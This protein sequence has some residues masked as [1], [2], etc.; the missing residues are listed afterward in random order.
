MKMTMQSAGARS[1][2]PSARNG[3]L[4]RGIWAAWRIVCAVGW[5]GALSAQTAPVPTI[6]PS[7]R[8]AVLDAYQRYYIAVG[9]VSPGFTG[10]VATGD[11]G[12]VSDDY[13]R[14]TLSRINF[15]RA[16]AGLNGDVSFDPVLSAKCQQAALMMAV[17]GQLSHSPDSSW[18]D[19][20]ADGA[21]AANHSDLTLGV[22]GPA[23]VA[24]YFQD[25]GANNAIVGHRH[26]LLLAG[27]TVMG[28]GSIATSYNF[29]LPYGGVANAIWVVPVT[30]GVVPARP[31][32]TPA[33]VAWPTAGYFPAPLVPAR[34]SVWE[35]DTDFSGAVVQVWRD[36]TDLGT[37]PTVVA[38]REWFWEDA[39]VFS[40]VLPVG[41]PSLSRDENYHVQITGARRAS[42]G[43]AV[44]YDYTVTTI[45]PRPTPTPTPAV[46]PQ[47]SL[48][49]TADTATPLTKTKL[50]FT[51]T[52][53]TSA[54]LAVAYKVAGTAVGGVDYEPLG[55]TLTIPA[56]AASA[57]RKLKVLTGAQPDAT[58]EVRISGSL[59]Y[60]KDKQSKQVV[61]HLQP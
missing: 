39:L 29:A 9:S 49:A 12:T 38:D 21:E 40:P 4:L 47:I 42:T 2:Q 19:Y 16:L 57:R 58:V 28:S 1:R 26:W 53:D 51:R 6:E 32:N 17:Q 22:A 8:D 25:D 52:G 5:A 30:P 59:F 34:W 18:K 31:P 54:S 14:A 13:Q 3:R 60:R 50:V 10:N 27:Q 23:A 41:A 7:D 15:C 11:A 44:G 61:V 37:V 56:G 24:D 20:T 45:N 46:L 33:S 48:T 36:G 55:G 43:A 35:S